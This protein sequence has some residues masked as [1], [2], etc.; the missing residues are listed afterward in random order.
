MALQLTFQKQYVIS[1]A[2]ISTKSHLRTMPK[3]K[4]FTFWNSLVCWRFIDNDSVPS[5]N[6]GTPFQKVVHL[7]AT[8][9]RANHFIGKPFS[10][11]LRFLLPFNLA[12]FESLSLLPTCALGASPNFPL[13]VCQFY[14]H[15]GDGRKAW[16]GCAWTCFF[17]S[18]YTGIYL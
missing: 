4:S 1:E 15:Q 10:S 11:S 18:K 8:L 12:R 6:V 13:C 5:L 3:S 9:E 17:L 2:R 14:S 7:Q 16:G